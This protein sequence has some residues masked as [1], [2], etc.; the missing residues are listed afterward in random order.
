[1]IALPDDLFPLTTY[2][3]TNIDDKAISSNAC[4]YPRWMTEYNC[5]A[6]VKIHGTEWNLET[7]FIEYD[8]N[9]AYIYIYIDFAVRQSGSL[10][11]IKTTQFRKKVFTGEFPMHRFRPQTIYTPIWYWLHRFILVFL[12]IISRF[13]ASVALELNK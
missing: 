8:V 5:W 11:M 7:R 2:C 9:A 10:C 1:M 13:E 6:S 4:R 12:P 3:C